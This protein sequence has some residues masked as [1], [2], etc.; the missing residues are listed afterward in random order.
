MLEPVP[1]KVVSAEDADEAPA[2]AYPINLYGGPSGGGGGEAQDT[3]WVDLQFKSSISLDPSY[4]SNRASA[5]RV[6]NQVTWMISASLLED[7]GISLQMI[8]L[9]ETVP[10]G[11]YL[12]DGGGIP[13][14]TFEAGAPSPTILTASRA[15]GTLGYDLMIGNYES[16]ELVGFLVEMT[17]FTDEPFPETDP[18]TS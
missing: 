1:F 6:G 2:G 7:S 9:I 14:V 4:P 15:R 3:G 18:V 16:K 13:I 11:F 10:Q 8:D 17:G 5:R 12:G